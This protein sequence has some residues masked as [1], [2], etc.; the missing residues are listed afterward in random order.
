MPVLFMIGACGRQ[1]CGD[2]KLVRCLDTETGKEI[3]AIAVDEV[4]G[5]RIGTR[6]IRI[7][8]PDED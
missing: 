2:G 6:P 8:N 4:T 7:V 1:H 5:A 3:K